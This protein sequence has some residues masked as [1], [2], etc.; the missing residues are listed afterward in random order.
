MSIYDKAFNPYNLDSIPS[1]LMQYGKVISSN[2]RDIYTYILA[3]KI[4]LYF[5]VKHRDRPKIIH[6]LNILL[7]ELRTVYDLKYMEYYPLLGE[8]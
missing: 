6:N 1:R 5:M 2:D 4:T 3:V 7:F 8:L